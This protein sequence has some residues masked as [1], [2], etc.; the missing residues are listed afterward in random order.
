MS[1]YI[2]HFTGC[3][4]ET[5]STES[6]IVLPESNF[7]PIF[8][9]VDCNRYYLLVLG[10]ISHDYEISAQDRFRVYSS[11]KNRAAEPDAKSDAKPGYNC[12]HGSRG[13]MDI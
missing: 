3:N 13:Y 9:L 2:V 11:F 5:H 4:N 1:V 6:H 10:C 8:H 7:I 12:V